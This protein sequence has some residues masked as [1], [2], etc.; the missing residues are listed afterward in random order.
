MNVSASDF[1]QIKTVINTEAQ[2]RFLWA[3]LIFVINLR[4]KHSLYLD[5]TRREFESWFCASPDCF[6]ADLKPS[7]SVR[8]PCLADVF[9]SWVWPVRIARLA[10][11]GSSSFCNHRWLHTNTLRQ[12]W[13]WLGVLKSWIWPLLW[14]G[15]AVDGETSSTQH[16]KF[17]VLTLCPGNTCFSTVH[18]DKLNSYTV[19][20]TQKNIGWTDLAGNVLTTSKTGEARLCSYWTLSNVLF[21]FL[22][23]VVKYRLVQW[24]CFSDVTGCMY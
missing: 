3:V 24:N 1:W 18:F 17:L 21:F 9:A 20:S 8:I 19:K 2:P 15:D 7:T 14:S 11:L 13:D 5:S 23:I 4:P 6:L 10:S 22:T 16:S 12:M